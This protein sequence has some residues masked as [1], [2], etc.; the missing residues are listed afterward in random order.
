MKEGLSLTVQELKPI[1]CFE[2]LQAEWTSSET[3][4]KL[5]LIASHSSERKYKEK[6]TDT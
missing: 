4:L 1:K 5:L 2:Y 6:I 3:D